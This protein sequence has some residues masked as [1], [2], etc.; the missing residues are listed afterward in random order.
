MELQGFVDEESRSD[1]WKPDSDVLHRRGQYL[2][3]HKAE[4]TPTKG[5][6]YST[7][8]DSLHQ[9]SKIGHTEC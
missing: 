3:D 4:L 2:D 9:I 8:D 1:C 5:R 6:S 7:L